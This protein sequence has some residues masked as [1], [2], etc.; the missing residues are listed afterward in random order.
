MRS[1]LTG[2]VIGGKY[3]ILKRLGG[4]SFGEVYQARQMAFGLPLREVALKV[5]FREDNGDAVELAVKEALALAALVERQE[6]T[7]R[8]RYLINIYD[9]GLTEDPE[10]RPYCA[11]ELVQGGTLL[12]R[13][14]LGHPFPVR[15]VLKYMK[16]IAEGMTLLHCRQPPYVHRDLKP[17]NILLDRA[18]HIKIADFGLAAMVDRI[19]KTAPAG[20]TRSYQAPE[21]LMLRLCTP[22]TDVYSLGL[23]FYEMLTGRNPFV[24]LDS[25]GSTGDPALRHLEARKDGRFLPR[26]SECSLELRDYPALEAV[27]MRCLAYNPEDRYQSAGELLKDLDRCDQGQFPAV[28]RPRPGN[29]DAPSLID[30]G[31]YHM[32]NGD[33]DRALDCWQR[34]LRVDPAAADAYCLIAE[35]QLQAGGLQE[36]LQ[37]VLEGL[38]RNKCRK[39]CLAASKVYLAMG[40]RSLASAF[41]G[42]ALRCR[43]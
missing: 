18:G 30:E 31:R 36:A 21:S 10:A 11:M 34:A 1:D 14:R 9:A 4:G 40:N 35:A 13:I 37:T 8:R 7:G 24:G 39:T 3:M 41:S 15:G 27:V 26:P 33:R 19:L 29:H 32:Q 5:F 6:E 12:D 28:F 2:R 43:D 25:D 22:A 16:E 38:R 17:D 20:G 23:I 42:E